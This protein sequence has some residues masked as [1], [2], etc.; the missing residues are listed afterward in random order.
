MK[1][2]TFIT[3]WFCFNNVKAEQAIKSEKLA[4][5]ISQA[6]SPIEVLPVSLLS[7]TSERNLETVT[8]K[9]STI[10]EANNSHFI[11]QASEDGVIW[12]DLGQVASSA[13]NANSNELIN[14]SFSIPINDIFKESIALLF[15]LGLSFRKNLKFSLIILGIFLLA[16][17]NDEDEIAKKNVFVRLVQVDYDGQQSISSVIV[18]P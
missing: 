13:I 11:V 12:H 6:A 8:I 5:K 14:Y 9:W 15:F 4:T 16:A 18:V 7:F 17:C 1:F 3:L 2:L 10:S